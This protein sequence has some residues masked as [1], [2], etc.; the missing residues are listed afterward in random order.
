MGKRLE[1]YIGDPEAFNELKEEVRLLWYRK[2]KENLTNS[3]LM[4]YA[5]TMFKK[6]LLNEV[7]G[8]SSKNPDYLRTGWD[9]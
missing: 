2:F 8:S 6:Y 3:K 5:L 4:V 1:L 9:K 7:K